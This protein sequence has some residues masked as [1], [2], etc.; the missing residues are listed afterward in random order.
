MQLILLP[1]R[2]LAAQKQNEKAKICYYAVEPEI[3][4][5]NQSQ[6]ERKFLFHQSQ[7]MKTDQY[8]IVYKEVFAEKDFF[9]FGK[10]TINNS[11]NYFIVLSVKQQK[12][13]GKGYAK[14]QK[15]VLHFELYDIFTGNR[16]FHTSNSRSMAVRQYLHSSF[17]KMQK[18]LAS[19]QH[20]ETSGFLSNDEIAI[21]PAPPYLWQ[22]GI[23]FQYNYLMGD[24]GTQIDPGILSRVYLLGNF[25]LIPKLKTKK[26]ITFIDV[27]F[28]YSAGKAGDISLTYLYIPAVAGFGYR[29]YLNEQWELI[30]KLYSGAST[31]RMDGR[32]TNYAIAG[33]FGIE[34]DVLYKLNKRHAMTMTTGFSFDS[35]IYTTSRAIGIGIGYRY[36]F[37]F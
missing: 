28:H 8:D 3:N 34:L 4:S 15:T 17:S 11:C 24:I 16:V 10:K 12:D 14:K 2:G 5:R 1:A 6:I 21:E 30:P 25:F 33:L 18:W 35:N 23:L 31:S 13:A 36:G 20:S 32:V 26:I 19:N 22:T 9:A 29:I 7:T 27:G 37:D